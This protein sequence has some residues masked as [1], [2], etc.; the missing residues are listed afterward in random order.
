MGKNVG[1]LDRTIRILV[2]LVLLSGVFVGPKSLWGLIG[3]LPLLTGLASFCPAYRIAGMSTCDA[4][5]K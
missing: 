2:G 4:R 5:A 3:L 1:M